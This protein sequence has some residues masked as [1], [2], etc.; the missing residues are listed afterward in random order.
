MAESSTPNAGKQ[1]YLKID[2]GSVFGPVDSA[3]LRD[4]AEQ[5]RVAPGNEISPDRK[6]WLSADQLPELEMEWKVELRNGTFY[7]PL[8]LCTLSDLIAEGTVSETAKLVNVR[9]DEKTTVD[10]KQSEIKGKKPQV[11]ADMPKT[12]VT[13]SKSSED[14]PATEPA[15]GSNPV[16]TAATKTPAPAQESNKSGSK[17]VIP[18]KP[19]Q[20]EATA[21]KTKLD[22]DLSQRSGTL[23]ARKDALSGI[24]QRDAVEQLKKRIARSE[25]LLEQAQRE[26]DYEKTRHAYTREEV[27][28][29]KAELAS[30]VELARKDNEALTT[31]LRQAEEELEKRS[32]SFRKRQLESHER[33]Q[34][35][36]QEVEELNGRLEELF[37]S[38]EAAR[39]EIDEDRAAHEESSAA[40]EKTQSELTTRIEKL[41]ADGE[42][43]RSRIKQTE[44]QRAAVQKQLEQL[45]A[46]Q[47][48]TLALLEA[49]RK[50]LDSE[51]SRL[52]EART[53]ME[54]LERDLTAK[55][56]TLERSKEFETRAKEQVAQ[57]QARIKTLESDLATAR[58]TADDTEADAKVRVAAITEEARAAREETEAARREQEH[59]KE[60]ADAVK[61][62]LEQVEARER[63][64]T[65]AFKHKLMEQADRLDKQLDDER[66]S[67]EATRELSLKKQEA[68]ENQI[69]E[70]HQAIGDEFEEERE[71]FE[72]RED[73]LDRV[74]AL[75]AELDKATKSVDALK[76]ASDTRQIELEDELRRTK[77]QNEAQIEGLRE[78]EEVKKALREARNAVREKERTFAQKE[79]TFSDDVTR[80]KQKEQSLTRQLEE[81]RRS[82]RA[83]ST[84]LEMQQRQMARGKE[85]VRRAPATP[86]AK[87][88]PAEKADAKAKEPVKETVKPAEKPAEKTPDKTA[89]NAK[90]EKSQEGNGDAKGRDTKFNPKPW[91]TLE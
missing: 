83:A 82:A 27:N 46:D 72:K 16:K 64:L 65:S 51:K 76:K 2:D 69:I 86:A 56:A 31:K 88:K 39:M 20:T 36:E 54:D 18:L 21:A 91:M 44:D 29:R 42:Q 7:G 49:A 34:E 40:A 41:T 1:W 71:M 62:K 35:L 9:T 33:E 84:K 90:V 61:W 77:L 19:E 53:R 81:Q 6:S 10:Q 4:W 30:R 74:A 57:L 5:G 80:L 73:A 32:D 55:T 50:S 24:Q 15:G 58:K 68:I 23:R 47:A 52:S 25:S 89:K 11:K 75:E 67:L 78:L 66:A 37:N 60:V 63:K 85:P 45:R 13:P 8:N 70:L 28:Q 26:L 59:E 38:L 87:A 48:S 79:R 17:E 14:E 12:P 22:A 3:S 43:L